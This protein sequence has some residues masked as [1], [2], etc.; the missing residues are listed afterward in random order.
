MPV[1]R[2]A[3]H[4]CAF[5]VAAIGVA[6]LFRLHDP[7]VPGMDS[8]RHFRHAALYAQHGPFM[9]A[10]PWLPYSVVSRWGSDL[11]YGFNLL[12][13]PFTFVSD[14]IL[15]IKLAAIC[16]MVVLLLTFR[17][18]MRR[19][20][21]GYDYGWPFLLFFFAPATLYGLLMTRPHVLT[22]A[23]AALLLSYLVTNSG[24]GAFVSGLLLSWIHL[25]FLWVVPVSAAVVGI[26]KLACERV[27]IWRSGLAAMVGMALG[28]LLRPHPIGSAKLLYVQLVELNM[29]RHQ[30]VP[31]MYA[32]EMKPV[33]M[34][35]VASGFLY[36]LLIWLTLTVVFVISAAARRP[37][38]SGQD[39][40]LLWSS[41]A[42]AGLFFAMTALDTRRA[43]ALWAAY[44]VVFVA[45]AFSRLLNLD[46]RTPTERSLLALDT[47]IIIAVCVAL[48][49]AAMVGTSANDHLLRAQRWRSAPPDLMKAP[50]E[51]L[52]AHSRP[53]EIVF[54][55]NWGDYQVLFFRDTHNR[56][57]TGLD[58]IFLYAYNQGLY[59]K[60]HHLGMGEGTAVTWA[61]PDPT[62]RDAEDTYTVLRRDF[63]AS[64]VLL[65]KRVNEPLYTYLRGE[66]RFQPVFEDEWYVV[67]RL[68]G[69]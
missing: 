45:V 54:N 29:A 9:S 55:V 52:E 63:K 5:L 10:Y 57:V 21:V 15:G 56:Y 44:G 53:G 32:D 39:R 19:H 23:L 14:P 49:F 22:M 7:G 64:Y 47:R 62:P 16:E 11:W 65:S 38:V 66:A 2:R 42:L 60:A 8:F 34:P 33:P 18:V 1:K 67:Y 13:I 26:A 46:P 36:V 40:A 20:Q 43:V 24:R 17:F 68:A 58:P 41:L 37:E 61:T 4:L 50:C 31:L 30:G 69:S 48:L 25:N 6:A 28:W 27:W 59:W 51:W 3:C 12:L 35:E